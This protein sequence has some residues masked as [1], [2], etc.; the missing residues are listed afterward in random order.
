[1]GEKGG[2]MESR[3]RERLRAKGRRRGEE[4]RKGRDEGGQHGRDVTRC[5]RERKHGEQK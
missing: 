2:D 1:M 3:R 5:V 4:R